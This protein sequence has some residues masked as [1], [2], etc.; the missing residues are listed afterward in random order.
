L[1]QKYLFFARNMVPFAPTT[2][3]TVPTGKSTE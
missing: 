3:Y 1:K 2:Q